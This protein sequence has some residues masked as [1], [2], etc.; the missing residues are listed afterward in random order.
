MTAAATPLS[1]LFAET[2]TGIEQIL[3]TFLTAHHY[4]DPR[5][6]EA[7]GLL[8]DF[9]LRAGKRL[10][11]LLCCIG[12]TAVSGRCPTP[13]VLR[14]AASLELFHAFALIHD[15]IMDGSDTRRAGP[16]LHRALSGAADPDPSTA[17][18]A[19][20]SKAI[21]LGD[22]ALVWSDQ[23]LHNSG[24][25]PA[26]LQAARPVLDAMR[27]EVMGGQYLDV[28]MSSG[29]EAD[30]HTA[31]TVIRY[32]TAKYSFERPL[33]LGAAL[34][35]ATSNQLHELTGYA[36]PLGEAFQLRDDLLG[37]FGDPAVTGKSCLDD[38]RGN[39]R[40]VLIAVAFQKAGVAQRRRLDTLLGK[41]DLMEGE[42]EQVRRILVRTGARRRVEEMIAERRDQALHHLDQC[43][44]IS[45]ASL[46]PLREV[47][48]S[49]TRRPA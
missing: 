45:A 21:L 7:T 30:L 46:S 41:Q 10:R 4:Q 35:G 8:H 28:L 11:P 42:A 17:R 39:K 1:R 29:S 3:D 13:A 27:S 43:S 34:A 6:A 33:H 44:R 32:K 16:T 15:D 36:I 5:L 47:A 20:V 23:I 24:L 49:A 48:D 40:T 18:H 9:V 2:R 37:V 31:L 26:Q 25:E 19:G 12:Y 22:M 38:L 14:A